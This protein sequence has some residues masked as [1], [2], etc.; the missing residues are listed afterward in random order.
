MGASLAERRAGRGGAGSRIGPAP[1][2]P[3]GRAPQIQ[4]QLLHP[5]RT[6]TLQFGQGDTM[7]LSSAIARVV[8][9]FESRLTMSSTLQSLSATPAA[10]A[11]VT[12]KV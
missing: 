7:I 9:Y 11:G 8:V 6:H 12:R 2:P 10:I 4:I 3:S 5:L 1:P